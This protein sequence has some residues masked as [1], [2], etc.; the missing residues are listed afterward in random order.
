MLN[1]HEQ[2]AELEDDLI[3]MKMRFD[4]LEEMDEEDPAFDEDEYD[5]A[6][7]RHKQKLRRLRESFPEADEEH[8]T[9]PCPCGRGA[10]A[11]WPWVVQTAQLGFC[12]C[13]MAC[14]ER[15]CWRSEWIAAGAPDL[16]W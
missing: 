6:C 9:Q 2:Q 13:W 14:W 7:L 3:E 12:E 5:V 8:H 11:V 4:V 15:T 1:L 16:A 10:L